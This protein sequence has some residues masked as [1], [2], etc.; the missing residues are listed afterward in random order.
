MKKFFPL[1]NIP[2]SVEKNL[3]DVQ[4]LEATNIEGHQFHSYLEPISTETFVQGKSGVL[5]N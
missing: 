2:T 3:L 4:S 1:S 5:I